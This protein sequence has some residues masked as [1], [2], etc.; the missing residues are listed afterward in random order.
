MKKFLVILLACL[1][2][3]GCATMPTREEIAKIDYGA[4]I[5]IDYEQAIKQYCSNTLFDPYSAVYEFSPPQQYWVKQPPMLGGGLISG[6]MVFV[7]IN[8][9]N[10]MGGYTGTKRWGF[11]FRNNSISRVFD[12]DEMVMM[13]TQ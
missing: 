1:A 10:K 8:A 5:S 11:L 4:P 7:N 12:P 9:K 13:R 6:Y 2:L 3:S